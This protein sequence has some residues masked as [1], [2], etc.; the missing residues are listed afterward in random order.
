MWHR[1]L[2]LDGRQGAQQEPWMSTVDPNR[3]KRRQEHSK[4]VVEEEEEEEEGRE[5]V[6]QRGEG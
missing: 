4:D 5:L 2:G 6:S 1:F 3:R